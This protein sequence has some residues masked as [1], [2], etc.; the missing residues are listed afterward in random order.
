MSCS[1]TTWGTLMYGI[2]MYNV[3]C[4]IFRDL[5]RHQLSTKTRTYHVQRQFNVLYYR[6]A[7]LETHQIMVFF[8]CKQ[9]NTQTHT[10][11]VA[12]NFLQKK[13]HTRSF[14][15]FNSHLRQWALNWDDIGHRLA[16]CLQ[17]P[18]Q[19]KWEVLPQTEVMLYDMYECY[20]ELMHPDS[21][22]LIC[23]S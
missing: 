13:N 23:D 1:Q 15:S 5:E 14:L 2:A 22:F 16:H 19:L 18:L 12:A 9:D 21:W 17:Q 20:V 10:V 8:Q 3:T 6:D 7:S 4:Y 11:C